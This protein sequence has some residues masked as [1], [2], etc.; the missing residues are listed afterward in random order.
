MGLQTP[1]YDMHLAMGAKMF[2]FGGWDMPLHY[3]SQVEEHNQVRS[4][5]GIFDVSHMTI[6]D[7]SGAQA[8]E[9][10]RHVLSNDVERLK[11]GKGHYTAM[12][13]DNGGVIDDLIAFRT[14]SGF[15]LI[16]NAITRERIQQWLTLHA[17]SYQVQVEQR[18][19]LAHFSIQG[20]ATME[21]LS[22]I[23]NNSKMQLINQLAPYHCQQDGNWFI[24][25]T[26]YS[27]EE[28][29]EI[30]LPVSESIG[31][32]NDLIANGITPIGLG[33][34]DT[35]RLEAGFTL[36]G[37]DMNEQVSP[38]SANMHHVVALDPAERQF[39]GRKALE[40][41]LADG[42]EQKLV[43]LVLEERGVLRSGQ[44]VRISGG[45]DGVITSGSF[46]PTIGK[47]IALA[48]V[49]VS[50]ADRGEVEIRGKWYP[51]RVV[52]PCFVRHGKILI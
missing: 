39:I 11:P 27:G 4:E 30:I 51:V 16:N 48:R 32:F 22:G 46:S 36:L 7:I 40:Q 33:A 5:C 9:F 17:A 37:N 45:A 49:P 47:A 42:I 43:G 29:I 24:S 50:T 18:S 31:L 13:N 23:F 3:G 28:G 38:F 34:R 26:G 8:V 14:E 2:N 20:P 19:D 52:R 21:R 15:R 12:L 25:R 41:Q 1:L 35:L 6:T 10:L 44:P